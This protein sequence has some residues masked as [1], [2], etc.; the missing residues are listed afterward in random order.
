MCATQ[1]FRGDHSTSAASQ[2]SLR[3][4]QRGAVRPAV[5]SPGVRGRA[6]GGEGLF[7]PHGTMG[8]V[9]SSRR[10]T[11]TQQLPPTA[12]PRLMVP[13]EQLRSEIDE[14]L[15]RGQELQEVP[16]D[17]EDFLRERRRAYSTWS[18][19]NEALVRRS[20]DLPEP[21]EEYAR[22]A[23]FIGGFGGAAD[24]LADR[25][26]ELRNDISG[27]IRRLESLRERIP[28]FQ[29]HP[30]A[31]SPASPPRDPSVLGSDVFVVHGHDGEVKVTVARFLLKLL[32]REPVILHEQPDRGRTII[33]K[34]EQHAARA[35]CAVVLLTG[36][37]DGGPVGGSQQRRAR[38]NV[39]FELG[40]FVGTLGRDRVIILYE[41]QVELP[42][43]LDGVLYIELDDR[44]AWR[45]TV[46]R[47]LQAA[48]L[49]V[50][51][52]ALLS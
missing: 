28:L 51:L 20:F 15:A 16:I 17:S 19:Y 46:A 27:K 34:F 31:T 45:N 36:D 22:R 12:Q 43:D 44:G 23:P 6:G 5:R 7:T 42:S 52:A 35:G 30:D 37:D 1:S 2:T 32:G 47:E 10:R 25:W 29:M 3:P 14:R 49:N 33:E 50:D 8:P 4:D 38:Q 48:G 21:A 39:V 41:P 11:T 13:A 26:N 9:S 24:P 40:F 18:E